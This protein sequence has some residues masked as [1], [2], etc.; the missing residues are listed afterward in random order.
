MLPT[1]EAPSIPGEDQ[2]RPARHNAGSGRLQRL[3]CP[4]P[5]E[6]SQAARPTPGVHSPSP[7]LRRSWI[8]RAARACSASLRPARRSR[9]RAGWTPRTAA[10][11]GLLDPGFL[12]GA[13]AARAHDQTSRPGVPARVNLRHI[14]LAGPWVGFIYSGSGLAWYDN[15][16]ERACSLTTHP[17]IEHKLRSPKETRRHGSVLR[18]IVSA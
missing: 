6:Q 11:R 16:A 17:S 2:H 13:T 12:G 3:E 9:R 7:A 15:S 5:G 10:H 1:F 14:D 18:I 8:A 4:R